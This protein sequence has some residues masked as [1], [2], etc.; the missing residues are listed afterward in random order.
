MTAFSS[1]TLDL[2]LC[3]GVPWVNNCR[4]VDHRNS[5]STYRNT[6]I[7]PRNVCFHAAATRSFRFMIFI[8]FEC[9]DKTC[10][11]IERL[12][13]ISPPSGKTQNE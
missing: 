12:V 13:S 5:V 11:E 3:L 10:P 1:F 7:S 9:G 4:T 2:I 8:T 6:V